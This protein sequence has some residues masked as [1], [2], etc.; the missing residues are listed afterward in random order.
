[1]PDMTIP[2]AM[3]GEMRQ[4]ERRQQRQG[5]YR[6]KMLLFINLYICQIF[7][8]E[9]AVYYSP[10]GVPKIKSNLNIIFRH[11]VVSSILIDYLPEVEHRRG[12]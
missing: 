3:G 11:E 9:G 7:R 6:V 2:I 12:T 10:Y 4:G 5:D 1:M 8:A